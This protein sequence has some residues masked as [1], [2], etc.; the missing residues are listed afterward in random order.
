MTLISTVFVMHTTH[1]KAD[2][3][4]D[5][6]FELIVRGPGGYEA[7]GNFEDLDWDGEKEVELPCTRSNSTS[8]STGVKIGLFRFG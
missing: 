4:T 2:A 8:H 1:G 7:R 3:G 5:A 6:G